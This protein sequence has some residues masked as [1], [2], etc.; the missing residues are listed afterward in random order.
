M[1][2]LAVDEAEQ[3]D[4]DRHADRDPER[5][6]AERR[7]RWRMSFQPSID[8]SRQFANSRRIS[9][10]V[11]VAANGR[12]SQPPAAPRSCVA[13]YRGW[14]TG[15]LVDARLER[16]SPAIP[17]SAF[18][19]FWITISMAIFI[20]LLGFIY[21]KLFHQELGVFLPY[22]AIGLITWGFI[23]ATTTEACSAFIEMRH[24]QA[25]SI[26]VFDLCDADD[27]AQLHRVSAHRDPDGSDRDFLSHGYRLT[28]LLAIPG[29]FLVVLNQI[30]LS[31]RRRNPRYPVS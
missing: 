2:Q 18:G 12:D 31:I 11:H 14:R 22:I 28:A 7:Y 5:S 17:R 6:K 13:S 24:H 19:P 25:D 26:A 20:V 1:E 8:Q 29:M 3:H 27:L 16:H 10:A 4:E 21:S 15:A 9:R 23:S 30:W